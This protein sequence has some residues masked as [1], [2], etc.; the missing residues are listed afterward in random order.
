MKNLLQNHPIR[1]LYKALCRVFWA[2]LGL[3]V[4]LPAYSIEFGS[5]DTYGSLGTTI[6]LGARYRVEDPDEELIS[7]SAGGQ[8]FSA[9]IDDG[10][11]NYDTGI[12]SS[13]I[14][15]TSEFEFNYKNTGFFVR[16]TAFY[17]YENEDGDR[18]RTKLS[19]DALELV[20]SD[21]DLLDAYAWLKFNFG[22]LPAEIRA[23]NQLISWGESTFIQNSINVINPVNVNALRVPGSELKEALLPVP[24][25]SFNTS[26]S[27]NT[28]IEVFYQ[29]RWEE[30]EIDPNGSFF[31]TN[32]FAGAGGD[33]VMLGFGD[34]SDQGTQ[35]LSGFDPD[36]L[37]VKRD[38]TGEASDDGQYGVAFRVFS[39]KLNDTEFG[40]Y[41]INYHSR[42]PL[43]SG[44]TGTAQGVATAEAT[45]PAATQ[46]LLDA[47]LPLAQAIAGA[48]GAAVDA[49]AQTAAY[50]TEYPE[51]IKL[52]GASFNTSLGTTGVALQG[53]VSH[54]RDAPL[55]VDDVELLLAALSPL[56]FNPT[57]KDNQIGDFSGQFSTVI[58][59]YVL[60]NVS[61]FQ[62]T[63]TKVFGPML[64]ASSAVLV[65][66]A[67]V[68]HVHDMPDKDILRLNG[69]AT[70]TSGNPNQ[71]TLPGVDP[72]LP[73]GGAHAGK[74]AE[75]ERYFPD[76]TSWGY[77]IRGR[78]DYN[79]VIGA[80]NLSPVF[81][82]RHDVDGVTPGPGG[83]FLEGRKA[84]TIGLGASY[85]NTWKG[86]LSYTSFFGAGRHNLINDRDFIAADISYSF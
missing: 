70:N 14:K 78:L 81:A 49:Y 62:T 15:A 38:P 17:D 73:L 41:F 33:R 61:Q 82:W 83:N 23:G 32:D 47:G 43:I 18:E 28:S 10:N 48:A 20:G 25:V 51:D 84:I 74:D 67:A 46:A 85:Q 71:A 4:A 11:Q 29:T 72:G 39:P 86:N 35:L 75:D 53:E 56:V 65:A 31:S 57:Y 30:I 54:R 22:D 77:Q 37:A 7:T 27:E 8:A 58:P 68:T 42:L 80:V 16:G 19:D 24:I 44:R 79:N 40:F 60:R 6:S 50:F 26:L 45:F 21:A 34:V 64:G 52:L 2:A 76:A 59:G 69:D 55:Q 3:S 12:V 36:F 66:E 5:G 9:N 13:V 1:C 63:A